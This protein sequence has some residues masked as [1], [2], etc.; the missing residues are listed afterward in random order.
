MSDLLRMT[1]M[2]SGMDTESIIQQM[3][4]AKA[5]KVTNLK[6]DQKKLEWKQTLW[7]DLNKRIYKLYTGTLSNLRLSGSYANK[8]T[9][10][11][12]PTKATIVAGDG[13]VN[14]AQSLE[15]KQLAKSGYLTGAVVSTKSWK[16]TENTKISELGVTGGVMNVEVGGTS[17]GQVTVDP[18]KSIGEFVNDFNNQFAGNDLTMSFKDGKITMEGPAGNVQDRKSVV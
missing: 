7:Q 6:N 10:V 1:G 3:V 18:N 15:V 2:Y 12:D 11:S 17:V 13:A 8:K 16:V 14:G 4:K 9:K 5:Q